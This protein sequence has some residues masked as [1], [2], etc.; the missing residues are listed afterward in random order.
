MAYLPGLQETATSRILTEVFSGYDHNLKIAEGAWFEEENLSSDSY[1]LFS[2]RKRRGIM[3]QLNNPQ[4]I[5]SKDALAYVDGS[6]LY[7]NGYPVDGIMLSTDE[8]DCPKQMVSMGAYL[9][10]FPDAVYVN[11]QN[12]SDAGSLGAKFVLSG[13]TIR[14]SVCRLDG[15]DYD[16]NAAHMGETEPAQ[17]ADK[18]YWIDT[19]STIHVLKQYSAASGV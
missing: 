14:L 15:Q 16:L 19:S 4:G 6:R 13:G 5:I 2:P 1:P 3:Q 10:I 8:D 11:T 17:P 7:Y 9:C 12:L 18:D